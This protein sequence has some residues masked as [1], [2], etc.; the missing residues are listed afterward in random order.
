M[1]HG[2][3][4]RVQGGKIQIAASRCDGTLTLTV[5]NDGPSPPRADFAGSGIGC[6]NVRTLLTSLYGDAFAFSMRNAEAG[7]VEVSVSLPYV[8]VPRVLWGS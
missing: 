7:G 1:K 2:I 3:A 8:L 6:L 4:K 5:C